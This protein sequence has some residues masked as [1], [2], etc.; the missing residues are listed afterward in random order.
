M[1]NNCKF[2]ISIPVYKSQFLHEC[3]S[4]ILNQSYQNYE[5]II[6]N[7]CS[8]NPVD[9]IIEQFKDG[10]IRYYKNE[11]NTGAENVVNNFN[12]CL[13]KAQGEY[14]ILMGDDD[15]MS[16]YYLEEF[17]K[18]ILKYP[19]L[20]IYHCRSILINEFS[21]PVALT[22]SWP[23]FES[24]YDNIWH[25]LNEKREQFIAD[26]VFKTTALKNNGNFYFLPLAWG[27]DDITSF[28]MIGNKGIAHIN[29][30]I[31][32]YRRHPSNIS[33]IGNY[34]LKMKAELLYEEWLKKF[35][36]YRPNSIHD[37]I[38]YDNLCKNLAQLFQKRKIYIVAESLQGNF[39]QMFLKWIKKLNSL[40]L[41]N[42]ALIYSIFAYLKIK[43]LQKSESDNQ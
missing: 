6:V 25:R 34:E 32:N 16:P 21:K 30:P 33:A 11:K 4:S 15:S 9:S 12:I 22:S 39:F 41:S 40:G 26:F 18:L 27:T 5:L 42:S 35:L 17:L 3:I 1:S 24:I 37:D 23:E 10:R 7:D 31:L 38:V 13:S 2:S 8:P 43:K 14:F 20:D 28:K 19:D 36:E 29:K